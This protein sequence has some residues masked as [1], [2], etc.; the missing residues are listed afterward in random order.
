MTRA[1]LTDPIGPTDTTPDQRRAAR[2]AV[3]DRAHDPHDAALL[4]D[5]LGLTE[6]PA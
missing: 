6:E 3:A 4:L 2:L 5:A 1:Q